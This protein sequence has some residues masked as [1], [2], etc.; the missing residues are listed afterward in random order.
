VERKRD[1]DWR[2][3]SDLTERLYWLARVPYPYWRGEVS[4][5]QPITLKFLQGN[6]G[7]VIP[8]ALQAQWLWKFQ[9]EPT[10]LVH[11]YVASV[12]STPHDDIA[13]DAAFGI[14]KSAIRRGL[15]TQAIEMGRWCHDEQ[16][17]DGG[18][19]LR[20]GLQLV[21]IYNI[22]ADLDS[23]RITRIRDII[24][25][26]KDTL[27][28]VVAGGIDGPTLFNKRLNLK[29]NVFFHFEGERSKDVLEY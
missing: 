27:R 13:L 12:T 17:R 5:H 4:S 29:A 21:V 18:Y 10:M 3:A 15:V 16:H 1:N 22:G 19:P 8:D 28:F 9:S 26:L 20:D 7:I 6:K 11:P 24:W 14:Q 2:R 25:R 23:A